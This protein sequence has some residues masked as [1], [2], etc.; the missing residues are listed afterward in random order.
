MPREYA[1]PDASPPGDARGRH[2]G[3]G[4]LAAAANGQATEAQ[5]ALAMALS[6]ALEASGDGRATPAAAGDGRAADR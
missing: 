2:T 6:K 3:P 4:G 1:I 5:Q